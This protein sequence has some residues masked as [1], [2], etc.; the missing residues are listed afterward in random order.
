MQ[1][2][3]NQ[4]SGVATELPWSFTEHYRLHQSL[5]ATGD[6]ERQ[7]HE[8]D[9]CGGYLFDIRAP[10]SSRPLKILVLRSSGAG[11]LIRRS[12]LMSARVFRAGR[13]KKAVPHVR[14]IRIVFAKHRLL[15]STVVVA[16]SCYLFRRSRH[17]KVVGSTPTWEDF[18]VTNVFGC[19]AVVWSCFVPGP[20]VSTLT[21]MVRPTADLHSFVKQYRP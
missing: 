3:C 6:S 10:P 17:S 15:T 20:T 4:I 18:F 8:T 9:S 1:S 12:E 14:Y 11:L 16:S 13:M 5:H 7:F 21:E 2:Y 19:F